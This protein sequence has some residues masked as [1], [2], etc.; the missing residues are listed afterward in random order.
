MFLCCWPCILQLDRHKLTGAK[1]HAVFLPARIT[2]LYLHFPLQPWLFRAQRTHDSAV[3]FI[4]R[5]GCCILIL[6]FPW[7]S[8]TY[9][10]DLVAMRITFGQEFF[11]F[12]NLQSFII[13]LIFPIIPNFLFTVLSFLS[14]NIIPLFF[15]QQRCRGTTP[16]QTSQRSQTAGRAHPT[17]TWSTVL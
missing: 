4:P 7:G 15:C 12:Q 2:S 5:R 14:P 9:L 1:P 6:G 8:S 17:L 16:V 13:M 3:V 11:V 10:Y